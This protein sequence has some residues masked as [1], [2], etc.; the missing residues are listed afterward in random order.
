MRH[1]ARRAPFQCPCIPW[2]TVILSRSIAEAPIN[3][4]YEYRKS[5]RQTNRSDRSK[6]VQWAESRLSGISVHPARHSIQPQE[7]ERQERYVKARHDD[8][9]RQLTLLVIQ[10]EAEQFREPVVHSRENAEHRTRNQCVVEVRYQEHRVVVLVI[11]TCHRQHDTG[12]STDRKDRDKG[13]GIQHWRRKFDA[14]FLH[15]KQPVEYFDP[16]RNGNRHRRHGEEAVNHRAMTHR[17]EVVSPHNEGQY[18]DD[19][20]TEHHRFITVQVFA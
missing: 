7:E 5:N 20:H 12:H 17:I 18:R 14:A 8:P 2:I 10:A 19:D 13:K 11:R 1:R 3:V 6:Q 16:G 4:V 9:E 15:R